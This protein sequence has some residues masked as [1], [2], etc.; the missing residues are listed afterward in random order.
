MTGPVTLHRGCGG[1]IVFDEEAGGHCLECKAERLTEGEYERAAPVA[2]VTP[3][4]AISWGVV[5][6]VF[7]V[8]E[9]AGFRRGDDEHLGRAV[10][11]VYDLVAVYTGGETS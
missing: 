11:M 1:E 8:L 3:A 7:D 4:N 9:R 2:P 5:I 10:G 6:D